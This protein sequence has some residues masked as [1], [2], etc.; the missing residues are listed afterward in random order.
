MKYRLNGRNSCDT[1]Q[2]Y[3]RR[4]LE[5]RPLGNLKP[6]DCAPYLDVCR[7]LERAAGDPEAVDRVWA[8]A[9]A[10]EPELAELLIDDAAPEEP[11][12]DDGT[13]KGSVATQLVRLAEDRCTFMRSDGGSYAKVRNN[14]EV[15]PLGSKA[16]KEYLSEQYLRMAGKVA[17]SGSLTDALT[18]LRGIAAKTDEPVYVRTCGDAARVVFLDLGN[19]RVAHVTPSEIKIIPKAD[20]PV[21]LWSPSAAKALPDPDLTGTLDDI[22]AA[23]ALEGDALYVAAGWLLAALLPGGPYPVLAVY[24]PQGSGKSTRCRQLNRLLDP[25]GLLLRTQPKKTDDLIVAARAAHILSFD[26]VSKIS[27]ELSDGLCR[28]ATGGGIAKRT[29]YT[30]ADVTVVN[31]KRPVVINAIVDVV[32]RSDLADRLML[33]ELDRV[34]ERRTE[35][36]VEE[37]FRQHQAKA[38]GALLK[39]VKAALCTWHSISLPDLP[40]MADACAWA[41]AGMRGIGAEPEGFFNAFTRAAQ[42]ASA[43]IVEGDLVGSLVHTIATKGD[44]FLGTASTLLERMRSMASGQ[45][46]S[47]PTDATQLSIQLKRLAP[48]LEAAHGYTIEYKRTRERRQW[49][50]P[51]VSKNKV[52]DENASHA[53]HTSQNDT[54]ATHEAP[55]TVDSGECERLSEA[56]F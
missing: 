7:E 32:K 1:A 28:V 22:G 23:L 56:P 6:E 30:D 16:F 43:R 47:L 44:G 27:D 34:A 9:V 41:E 8:A 17:P 35:R 20:A 15:L 42:D 50:I 52:S 33:L 37:R 24:G 26:N 49:K 40:R 36:Q 13:G 11:S 25:S 19:G 31:V 46:R 48:A 18:A 38:L 12:G 53:S 2:K 54:A 10:S 51:S 4:V 55:K 14:G 29:L 5:G 3:I 45:K 21:N 39:G